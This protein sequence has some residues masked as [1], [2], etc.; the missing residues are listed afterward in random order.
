MF[1]YIDQPFTPS[2]VLMLFWLFQTWP[3]TLR[4]QEKVFSGFIVPSDSKETVL[5]SSN[6]EPS[7]VGKSTGVV[8]VPCSRMEL[9]P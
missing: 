8:L 1:Y 3:V 9:R 5:G 7:P 6:Q 4:I 2:L